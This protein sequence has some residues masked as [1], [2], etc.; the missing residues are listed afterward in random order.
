MGP[1]PLGKQTG[2]RREGPVP[3]RVHDRAGSAAL[4]EKGARGQKLASR[5]PGSEE[6]TSGLA[7]KAAPGAR[8]WAPPRRR[9]FIPSLTGRA[10]SV[11]GSA[12][13]GLLGVRGNAF[14]LEQLP[15]R[16]RPHW[17]FARGCRTEAAADWLAV[18]TQAERYWVFRALAGRPPQ[19]RR[20]PVRV[21]SGGPG[22]G[23]GL[24]SAG[25]PN[26]AALFACICL[27]VS[28]VPSERAVPWT[29]LTAPS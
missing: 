23:G 2:G 25:G 3:L 28:P 4:R 29:V 12:T 21:V 1:H 6:N 22:A 27:P 8:S 5:E 11:A 14:R 26:A 15:A 16:L 13:G 7:C 19:D 24:L 20:L 10:V 17:L 9:F 18:P